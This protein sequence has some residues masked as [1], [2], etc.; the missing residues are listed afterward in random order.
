MTKEVPLD[1]EEF[2][3]LCGVSRETLGRLQTYLDLLLRWQPKINLVS[4]ATLVDPWRR[5]MLDSAQLSPLIKPATAK[6]VDLGSGAG[7]PGLVLA[8]MAAGQVSL[9][10][11]DQRKC[12]FLREVIRETAAEAFVIEGRIELQR[13]LNVDVVTARGLAPLPRLLGYAGRLLQPGGICL[14]LKGRGTE[15]ELTAAS[16]E[17]NMQVE[18]FPSLT[19]SGSWILRIGE[20]T[21][22][23]HNRSTAG[24]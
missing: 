22:V 9:I 19:E 15:E 8:I 11:S 10:E 23:T 12:V 24:R 17:W 20:L 21:H 1:P 16:K 13:D 5:H 6:I 4:A 7:F 3:E 14:F 2:R 18:K